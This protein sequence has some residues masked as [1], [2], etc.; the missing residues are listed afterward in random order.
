MV[1][2]VKEFNQSRDTAVKM[3]REQQFTKSNKVPKKSNGNEK[4]KHCN[5][6]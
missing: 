5:E 1:N 2:R 3:L 6:N 4:R